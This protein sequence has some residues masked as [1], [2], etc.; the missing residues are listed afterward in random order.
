M[1]DLLEEGVEVVVTE[2]LSM[3]GGSEHVLGT[4]TPQSLSIERAQLVQFVPHHQEGQ[5]EL[6]RWR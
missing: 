4:R 6:I 1:D 5:V 3:D 2:V